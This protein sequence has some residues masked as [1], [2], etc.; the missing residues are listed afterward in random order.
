MEV[1][2]RYDTFENESINLG[3]SS[4]DNAL[5]PSLG[6]V[7]KT[8]EGKNKNSGEYLTNIPAKKLVADL[9]QAVMQ[10]DVYLAWDPAMGTFEGLHV[11]SPWNISVLK[12]FNLFKLTPHHGLYVKGFGQAFSLTGAELLDV[13]W[14]RDGHHG[15]APKVNADI[16][17][18][19]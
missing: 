2:A 11:V 4:D 12:D 16:A 18:P 5:S 1:A 3:E 15:G 14:K 19:A 13:D 6:L 7:W 9:S 17:E 8:T 10:G